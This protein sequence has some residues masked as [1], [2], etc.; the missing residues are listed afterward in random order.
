MMKIGYFLFI[1][2]RK[3]MAAQILDVDTSNS[4]KLRE[5][6]RLHIRLD[7]TSGS[8]PYLFRPQT[9]GHDEFSL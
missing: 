8:F 3:N 2:A 5:S 7:H 1:N 9:G 6:A 4:A